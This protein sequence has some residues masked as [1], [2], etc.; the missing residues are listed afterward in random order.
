MRLIPR[1]VVYA[2]AQYQSLRLERIGRNS[3]QTEVLQSPWIPETCSFFLLPNTTKFGKWYR[4]NQVKKL[5]IGRLNRICISVNPEEHAEAA[6]KSV[7]FFKLYTIFY[8]IK[9]L[10]L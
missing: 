2:C 9:L 10:N 5:K 8:A 7:L 4:R 6:K 1:R 3:S